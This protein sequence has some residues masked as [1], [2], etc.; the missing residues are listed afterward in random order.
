MQN[1]PR[2]KNERFRQTNWA[3]ISVFE[4]RFS[5]LISDLEC[6]M[7]NVELLNS[8]FWDAQILFSIDPWC[9]E[10]IKHL[11]KQINRDISTAFY[12]KRQMQTPA[13]SWLSLLFLKS[14]NKSITKIENNLNVHDTRETTHFHV[15][16]A[17]GRRK[18]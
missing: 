16:T 14:L 1:G 9:W 10:K 15:E 3:R 11:R 18:S 7:W 5:K 2:V 12:G 17:N 8:H 4:I 13:S 6:W